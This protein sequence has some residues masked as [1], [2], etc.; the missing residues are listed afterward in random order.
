MGR[1]SIPRAAVLLALVATLGGPAVG[2]AAKPV[3]PDGSEPAPPVQPDPASEVAQPD[4][5]EAPPPVAP[6]PVVAQPANAHPEK[7]GART[8]VTGPE[9]RAEGGDGTDRPGGRADRGGVD[10]SE[11]AGDRED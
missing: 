2:L 10:G 1:H 6:E 11:A 3:Q 9:E 5:R 4:G 8:T 7:A